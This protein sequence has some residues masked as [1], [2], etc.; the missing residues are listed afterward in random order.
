MKSKVRVCRRCSLRHSIWATTPFTQS[1]GVHV[2][3][4]SIFYLVFSEPILMRFIIEQELSDTRRRLGK[5]R[6]Q[7]CDCRAE[8]KPRRRRVYRQRDAPCNERIQP[9]L[10]LSNKPGNWNSDAI[11]SLTQTALLARPAPPGRGG[12]LLLFYSFSLSQPLRKQVLFFHA[13]APPEW[14]R[15]PSLRRSENSLD[16]ANFNAK[17]THRAEI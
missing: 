4:S 5:P 8:E 15:R 9:A 7:L 2:F 1:R 13:R 3:I 10:P 17:Y 14:S 11:S 16:E 12:E 6:A